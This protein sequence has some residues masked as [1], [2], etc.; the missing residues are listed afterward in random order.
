MVFCLTQNCGIV[1]GFPS[2]VSFTFGYVKYCIRSI[3]V[4]RETYAANVFSF[5][6]IY[7]TILAMPL[8]NYLFSGNRQVC[9][10]N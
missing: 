6:T 2:T 8:M 1:S 4:C 3:V 10:R 5:L 9:S 7:T